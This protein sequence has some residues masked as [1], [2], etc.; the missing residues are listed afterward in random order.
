MIFVTVGTHYLGFERLIKKM[1]E[2]SCVI[3]DEV[4][5]QTGY[6][7]Y[8]PKN[9]K[10]A[11]FFDI[12]EINDFYNKADIIISHAGAG[13]LINCLS[14]G[15]KIIVV[16]RFKKFNE[17]IDDQQLELAEALDKS[18]RAFV[19]YKIENITDSIIKIKNHKFKSF[20][21]NENLNTFL[22]NE[23]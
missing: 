8:E 1:D 16:P 5:M 4:I 13:T 19:V 23:L 9:T 12:D 11:K 10:W 22:K 14:I 20:S 21:R 18:N 3:K 6:T 7:N 17:H 2:I 15:K